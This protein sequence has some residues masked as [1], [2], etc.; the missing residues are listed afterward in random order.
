[1]RSVLTADRFEHQGVLPDR[2]VLLLWL[3]IVLTVLFLGYR[4]A[5]ILHSRAAL[6][7]LTAAP[8]VGLAGQVSAFPSPAKVATAA[9]V[10]QPLPAQNSAASPASGIARPRALENGKD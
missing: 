3:T 4:F 6:S 9:S 1:M 10:A 7:E 2:E 5:G 8:T